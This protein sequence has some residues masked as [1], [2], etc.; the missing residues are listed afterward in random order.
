MTE[1]YPMNVVRF[2]AEN[3][4]EFELI[5]RIQAEGNFRSVRGVKYFVIVN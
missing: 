2:W 3:N 1:I 4:L 5:K